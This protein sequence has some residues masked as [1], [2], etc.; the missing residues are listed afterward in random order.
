MKKLM[1]LGA[2]GQ[3]KVVA[4]IARLCG[5]TDIA[6]LDDNQS[7][8]SWVGYPVLGGMGQA[9]AY[10]DWEFFIAIGNSMLR[11]KLQ[12]QLVQTGKTVATLIHPNAVVSQSASV[13]QGSVVMAGA[14]INPDAVIGQGCIINTCA[15]VD[16]DCVVGDYCH[17]SVGSHLAGTVK[18]G[19]HNFLGIGAV[20]SNNL[21]LCNN[22]TIGAGAVVVKDIC[23]SGT[24]VGVPAKKL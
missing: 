9:G 20:V 14:V 1:I 2:G 18:V 19:N 21:T 3:G 6:F 17:I 12:Q 4:D 16:H 23:Q 5:Y 24:Y 13:G 15:S 11:Q 22:C 8:T 7:L 10:T